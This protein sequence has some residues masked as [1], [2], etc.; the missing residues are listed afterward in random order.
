MRLQG[1][2]Y[3]A[4]NPKWSWSP[5][6]GEGARMH[7][8]RFNPK[9][10]AAL[11]LSLDWSTAIIEASQGFAFRIPPLTIVSYDIDCE[12]IAD[13]TSAE[14]RTRHR[15]SSKAMACAWR[16]LADSGVPVPSWRMAERLMEAGL[17]GVIV[18][19][20]AAGA[21]RDAKNLVLWRWSEAPPHRVAIIDLER[22][23]PRNATSWTS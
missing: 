4:H 19:S 17:A 14:E 23:L 6:S 7:G 13:L 1:V 20:F 15:V 2:A 10:V 22:R 9:G 18:P 21:D 16:L 8:G 11:Y 3:R 12:D 5:L